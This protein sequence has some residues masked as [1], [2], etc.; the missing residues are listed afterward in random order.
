MLWSGGGVGIKVLSLGAMSIA[1][2]RAAFAAAAMI[3][4]TAAKRTVTAEIVRK[5]LARPLVWVV[6]IA[7]AVMV[8]CFCIAA[9][10][11]TAANAIFIQYM[12]PIYVALLSGP[13]LGERVRPRDWLATILSVIGMALFFRGELS[14]QGRVGKSRRARL[15]LW[16]RRG[17]ARNPA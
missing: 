13:I 8:V 14:T 3:L 1:G 17:A 9:K 4:V 10:K 12:G 11:T 15:Q 16:L 2:Y 5:T 7:Y 6:A